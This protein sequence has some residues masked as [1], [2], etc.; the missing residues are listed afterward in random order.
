LSSERRLPAR[1]I[2][3]AKNSVGNCRS[4]DE[5]RRPN[6]G[7]PGPNECWRRPPSFQPEIP[8]VA[9]VSAKENSARTMENFARHR[10]SG[11]F[12]REFQFPRLKRRSDTL[13]TAADTL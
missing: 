11:K 8:S 12:R 6:D 7:K 13:K 9:A 4:R 1:A 10:S 3:P 5:T 2:I